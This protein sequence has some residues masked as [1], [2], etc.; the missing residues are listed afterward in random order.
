MNGVTSNGIFSRS[1]TVPIGLL[2][3]SSKRSNQTSS[4]TRPPIGSA[5]IACE[6]FFGSAALAPAAPGAAGAV[7]A[8]L[9]LISAMVT[10][11]SPRCAAIRFGISFC[12]AVNAARNNAA[13]PSWSL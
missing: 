4:L 7:A 2:L 6:L 5:A 1:A 10:T 3:M 8:T 9:V 12:R 11:L 13:L